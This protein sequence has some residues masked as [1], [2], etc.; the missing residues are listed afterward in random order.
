MLNPLSEADL[1]ALLR[2]ALA[3]PARGLGAEQLK[4]DSDA[5]P[6]LVGAALG[7]A[8]QMLGAL[9]VA[10]GLVGKGGQITAVVAREATQRQGPA[11]DEGSKH[12]M[13]SAFHKS[14][15]ASHPDAALYWAMR[16]VGAGEDPRVLL[17]RL[18]AAAYEDVGLADPQ[19]AMVAMDA[20]RAWDQLGPPEGFLALANGIVYV[21][22]APK[23]NRAYAALN[24][25]RAAAERTAGAPVPMALRNAHTSL[26]R[27]W[28]FG[29]GYRYAHDHPD[30]YATIQSL[31]D[32]LVGERFYEPSDRGFEAKVAARMAERRA[33]DQAEGS[34]GE[35]EV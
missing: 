4:I 17:R 32:A 26:M 35:P 12:Q 27:E 21:A 23:S 19:A 7:D 16:L 25:A 15:R 11:L 18:V 34:Q 9:E 31:P 33:R 6:V 5:E 22:Q 20:S 13:L 28:G 8:R 29:E 10:A 30:A 1:L 14:L 3:D 24:A 2:R